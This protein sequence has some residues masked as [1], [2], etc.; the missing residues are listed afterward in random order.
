MRKL[1]YFQIVCCFS[2]TISS[3]RY[4]SKILV[5]L[6]INRNSYEFDLAGSAPLLNRGHKSNKISCKSWY[7]GDNRDIVFVLGLVNK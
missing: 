7:F 5:F 6:N 4:S 3:S 1:D 2:L